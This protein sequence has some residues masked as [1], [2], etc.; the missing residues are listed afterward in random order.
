MLIIGDVHGCI[1]TFKALLDKEECREETEIYTVGDLIDR[2]PDSRACVQ[3]CIDRGI[4]A[5]MG[6]HEHMF[7]DYLEDGGVYQKG[8][9]MHNGG[10]KTLESYPNGVDGRHLDYIKAM[11]L[12]IETD[13]CIISHAGVPYQCESVE[14][15]KGLDVF[16]GLLWHREAVKVLEKLQIF[17]HTPYG[18]LGCNPTTKR[19][20]IDLGCVYPQYGRLAGVILREKEP[21]R[22]VIVDRI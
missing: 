8:I 12:L 21:M 5:V 9:F 20:N 3:L 15:A 17:G 7:I 10:N 2:G 11:P 16:G 1:E 19:F 4:Q 6:N 22:T 18:S 13:L 14:E